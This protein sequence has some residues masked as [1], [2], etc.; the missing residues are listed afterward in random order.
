MPADGFLG[1]HVLVE[2]GVVVEVIGRN[3][4]NDRNSR[5]A[6]EILQLEAGELENDEVGRRD[7]VEK[8]HRG[9]AYVAPEPDLPVGAV[10]KH[11]EEQRTG[12]P[13][14][15]GPGDAD[16]RRRTA[17]EKQARLAVERRSRLP[18]PHQGRVQGA[19]SRG[20]E[21]EVELVQPVQVVGAQVPA[22]GE[23]TPLRGA[24]QLFFGPC[25][26]D[27]ESDSAFRQVAADA[28]ILHPHAQER[29][30]LFFKLFVVHSD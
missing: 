20:A 21:E 22:P 24:G 4:Q 9:C 7:I 30:P 26:A 8:I 28:A 2:A 18:G 15:L 14:S 10:A 27:G 17:L 1:F 23:V 13:L 5:A 11:L 6:V 19:D 12:G 16:D 29:D 3:V 25:V